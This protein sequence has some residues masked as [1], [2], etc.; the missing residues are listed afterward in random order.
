MQTRT[1]TLASLYLDGF[2]DIPS[3]Q[4][5]YSWEEPQ[6]ADLIDDLRYLPEE[7]NHFFGN[8]ILDKKDEQYQTD[9]GRRFDVYDV[10]DGQQRLTTALILL[11]VA[12]QFDD[13]VDETVSEDNLIFPVDERPRLMPQDQDGEFFRDSLFGSANLECETPSQERLEYVKE[14]FESEFE[15]LPVREISERLRYDCKINVVEIDSDSEAASIFES[16]N[17][18]GKPL[19]SLDKTKSFLMYM[20]DRSSNQGALE[21]KIKQ[22]FGSIYRELFV[23]SNGHDRVSDFDE[24]SV[25]RFH[26]GIYD[27]YD[28]DEYFNSLDT[29]KDRLRERYRNGEYDSVQD[30]IDEYTLNLREAASAF[31]A[32]FNPSQRPDEVESALKRLL[33]LGRVANVLPVL[34]AAQMEY[35]DDEPDKMADIIHAC[36]TLVF[37]V[38][39]TDGR[40]SDTGRGRLVRLAHSIHADE[41]YLFEDVL[42]RLDSITR[43]YTDDDRFERNLRD[44]DFYESMSSQD[45]RYLFY[46]YGQNLDIEIREDVQRDLE[47]ILSTSF[48]VE[49]I[50]ARKLPEEDI[51]EDLREEFDDNVH[52]LGN[53]TVASEYWNKNYGNLPFEQKKIA[54]EG[55]EAEYKSSNL[56][57]QQSL[58][59]YDEFGRAEIEEREQKIV[60]FVLEEWGI[61]SEPQPSGGSSTGDG[62]DDVEYESLPDSFFRRLTNRQEAFIRILLDNGN[63]MMNEDVRQQ[64]EDD[65]DLATGGGQAISGILSGFTR[66]YSEDFTYRLIDYEWMGDQMQYRLHPDSG[67]IDELRERLEVKE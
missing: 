66:K 30:E 51:P 57:V 54:P 1:E 8:I 9:R 61:A 34:M 50:L 26:W 19:S 43:I 67:Y 22:R 16:L 37:R 49:H 32:L 53:L 31:A 21:T 25:Q 59:D 23:L 60:D 35:G 65:Y 58:A 41:S 48:E 42:N 3:Y 4:R 55:R 36:E 56:R 24:D 14:Y 18:R 33:A 62:S 38:Y 39:A 15:E 7:T 28:S 46:H 63:W 29:L 6:L 40:R 45:I 10:V 17:D 47:Q 2:F 20:D 5:S 44:P 11:H 13:V 27:G 52:R 64:M 12:T